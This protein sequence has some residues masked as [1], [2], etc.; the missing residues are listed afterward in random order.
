MR[1]MHFK[2]LCY[3]R[4]LSKSVLYGRYKPI[5]C[6]VVQMPD[7]VIIGDCYCALARLGVNGYRLALEPVK[8]RF[9][10]A[11]D[12]IVLRTLN[13]NARRSALIRSRDSDR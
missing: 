13:N 9:V 7:K 3:F 2:I 10:G 12:V 8:R 4:A 5:T 6:A 1:P 11:V